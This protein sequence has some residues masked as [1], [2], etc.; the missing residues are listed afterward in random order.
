MDAALLQMAR[1]MREET[2]GAFMNENCTDAEYLQE[3][4]ALSLDERDYALVHAIRS[5]IWQ[6]AA[7]FHCNEENWSIIKEKA[8]VR[9]A[10]AEEQGIPSFLGTCGSYVYVLIGEDAQWMR[11]YLEG[12]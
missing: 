1:E 7:I 2:I 12:L 11:T 9:C 5:D 10:Q 4:Y 3:A 6:E 8:Q